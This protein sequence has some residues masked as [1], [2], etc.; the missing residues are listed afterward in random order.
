MA[1]FLNLLLWEHSPL[2]SIY[3]S[4]TNWKRP[5]QRF[6]WHWD[7]KQIQNSNDV[8]SGVRKLDILLLFVVPLCAH[9]HV[10][11]GAHCVGAHCMGGMCRPEDNLSCPFLSAILLKTGSLIDPELTKQARDLPTHGLHY[12]R[13]EIPGMHHTPGFLIWVL[14]EEAQ[15]LVP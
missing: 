8:R 13:A 12:L 15:P 6:L 9:A 2:P 5:N 14:G 10:G 11:V 1:S 7:L 4:Q 3:F